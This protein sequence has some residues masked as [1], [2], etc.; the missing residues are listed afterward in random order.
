[1][2]K[3]FK[4]FQFKPE[5]QQA[6]DDAGYD[7][8]TPIQRDAI[9]ILLEGQ[10]LIGV[11][12]T[13]TGKTL[14]FLLPIFEK[15]EP[16]GTDPRALIVCP[17]RELAVQVGGEATRFGKHLGARTV[18]A[19]GGTS[20]NDQKRMLSEG[21]DIVVDDVTVSSAANRDRD[22][23]SLLGEHSASV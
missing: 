16:G 10:D 20:S 15:L 8:P 13:G 22:V 9:P 19:Y 1:M 6:L 5:I 18:L 12:E 7:D 21:C 11:A 23:R 2:S 4:D 14:A 3:K 17:T